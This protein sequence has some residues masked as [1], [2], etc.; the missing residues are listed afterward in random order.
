MFN[1][2]GL[3]DNKHLSLWEY[4]VMNLFTSGSTLEKHLIV[5]FSNFQVRHQW[6]TLW[7]DSISK[8][9]PLAILNFCSHGDYLFSSIATR[10]IRLPKVLKLSGFD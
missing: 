9:Q 7:C 8:S 3:L 6:H 5:K 1:L 2:I 10:N 4:C